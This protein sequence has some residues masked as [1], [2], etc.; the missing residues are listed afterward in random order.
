[1]LDPFPP[2]GAPRAYNA[3]EI[4]KPF[5][6]ESSVIAPAFSK[7]GFVIQYRTTVNAETLI[8]HG[9]IKPTPVE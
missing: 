2:S 5:E 4:M 1:M 3:Y 6:V 7:L 9:I 8:K